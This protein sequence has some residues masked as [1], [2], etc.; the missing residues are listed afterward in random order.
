MTLLS[1]TMAKI[2]PPR[3]QQ[4]IYHWTGNNKS[5][6]N[7]YF[8]IESEPLCQTLWALLS[9]FGSFYHAH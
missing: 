5:Y 8:F 3:N 7:M 2:G 1:E 6:P 4:I 9:N